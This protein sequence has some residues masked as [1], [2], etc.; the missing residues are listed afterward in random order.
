MFL[1]LEDITLIPQNTVKIAIKNK[2]IWTRYIYEKRRAKMQIDFG[3]STLSPLS[4][5]YCPWTLKWCWQHGQSSTP[6]KIPLPLEWHHKPSSFLCPGMP[7]Q[8][9]AIFLGFYWWVGSHEVHLKFI[10]WDVKCLKT[11][12]NICK[13]QGGGGQG[14]RM[15]QRDAFQCNCDVFEADLF[16]TPHSYFNLQI[17]TID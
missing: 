4:L 10:L 15:W 11:K 6:P 13:E 12:M 17:N 2:K 1:S 5:I 3:V 9:T 14:G 16:M 7:Y 8:L